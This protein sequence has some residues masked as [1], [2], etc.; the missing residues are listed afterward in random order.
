MAL[1]DGKV[2]LVTGAG[3]GI[4]RGHALEL[5]RQGARVVVNDLGSTA[6]GEG[7]GRD[8]DR[9]VEIITGAGGEAVADYGDVGD[10][11][12]ADAMVARGIDEWGHLD[13]VVNNAGIVRDRAI[14]NMP[15][16]DFDLVMRVHVRGTWLVSRAAARHW[17]ERAKAESAGVNGRIVNTVSGAGLLGN[18]GQSNYATAKAA[19][20]GLTLTLSLELASIGVTVNAIGPGA[21][22]RLSAGV[23]GGAEPKEPDEYAPDEFDPL[24]P[25]MSAPVVAWLASDAASHVSGQCI[26]AMRT[27][28]HLMQG[29]TEARTIDNGGAYWDAEKLGRRMDSELFN[30]RAPGLSLGG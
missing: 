4:G 13:V 26:R 28:I 15:V 2:A 24:N 20:M 18:F 9:V 22:T 11:A 1:L 23:S 8:A 12:A 10:E 3:H 29:W 17:R 14:W 19:I 16:D 5:A 21:V 7:S 25:A 6:A 27:Q 30:T